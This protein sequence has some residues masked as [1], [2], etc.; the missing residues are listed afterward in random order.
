MTNSIAMN[1]TSTLR[2]LEAITGT[3]IPK[4]KPV[5]GQPGRLIWLPFDKLVIDE[6]Y[7]RPIGKAGRANVLHILAAFDWGKFEPVIVTPLGHDGLYAIVDGQ[8]RTTAAYMHPAVDEVPCM[9]VDLTPAEAADAFAAIN[10]QVTAVTPTQIYAARL[11]AGDIGA[12]ALQAVLERAGVRVLKY[13]FPQTPYEVGDT[14]AVGTLYGC[15][16]EYGPLV[17]ERAL[18]A[19]TKSLDGNPGAV[20]APIIKALC[21]V[22]SSTP[23]WL[24]AGERLWEAMDEAGLGDIVTRATLEAKKTG[25]GRKVIVEDW[26]RDTIRKGLAGQSASQEAGAEVEA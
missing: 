5:K 17:L 1:G 23:A 19:I 21:A 4:T 2:R 9:A 20:S 3:D 10:G 14:L 6:R 12:K 25:R 15:L 11:A 7:Q 26:L 18:Q 24:Q 16:K 13:K 22:L 8:H